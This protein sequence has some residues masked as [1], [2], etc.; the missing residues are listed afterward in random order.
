MHVRLS[1]MGIRRMTFANLLVVMAA[2]LAS[3][4]AIHTG[5]ASPASHCSRRVHHAQ[6]QHHHHG[7]PANIML[8]R[9]ARHLGL[10]GGHSDEEG[11]EEKEDELA[12][13]INLSGDGGVHKIQRASGHLSPLLC[14]GDEIS[15]AVVR[16]EI[17]IHSN[18]CECVINHNRPFLR[19]KNVLCVCSHIR[20]HNSMQVCLNLSLCVCLIQSL[21]NCCV[22][23]I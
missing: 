19:A 16:G 13:L 10:R 6:V 4:C 11:P 21:S 22:Y 5:R 8:A 12:G 9:T 20:K 18:A 1:S 3:S 7:V 17:C 15:I 23:A 14:P 2:C